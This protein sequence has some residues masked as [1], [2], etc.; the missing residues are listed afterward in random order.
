MFSRP[1]GGRKGGRARRG[2]GGGGRGGARGAAAWLG[3]TVRAVRRLI[4][5][6]RAEGEAGLVH[7]LLGPPSNCRY[8]LRLKARVLALYA[9]HD[10][11]FGPTVAAEKLAERH[12]IDHSAETLRL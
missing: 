3:V 12:H 1:R 2:R 7:R 4:K 6:L 11:D 10:A 9:K 5:R 8:P